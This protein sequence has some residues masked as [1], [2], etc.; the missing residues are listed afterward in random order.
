MGDSG[1]GLGVCPINRT[2]VRSS[3]LFYKVVTLH[4]AEGLEFQR[5]IQEVTS[6]L[7]LQILQSVAMH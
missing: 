5:Q 6:H 7:L 4:H 1:T 3:E 2:G